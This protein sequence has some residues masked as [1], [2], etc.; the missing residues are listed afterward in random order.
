[1][2]DAPEQ[3]IKS[4]L[5][6]GKYYIAQLDCLESTDICDRAADTIE[7]LEAE[8]DKLRE[9]LADAIEDETEFETEWNKAA[10]AA[11]T[12]ARMQSLADLG[13]AQDAYEAQK[14]AEAER[15]R[16]RRQ[17]D[18]YRDVLKGISTN[19]NAMLKPI[20]ETEND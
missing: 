3:G 1:M 6:R 7:A 12:D 16:Y 9:L 2:T 10:R 17:R 15:D 13:Q 18:H 11:L 4:E 19:I 20:G 14:K 8:R 5:R